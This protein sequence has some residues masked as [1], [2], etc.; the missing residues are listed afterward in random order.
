MNPV[1]RQPLFENDLSIDVPNQ[2]KKVLVFFKPKISGK[3]VFETVWDNMQG[4]FWNPVE[5]NQIGYTQ[6]YEFTPIVLPAGASIIT[7][8]R[9]TQIVIPFGR[10]FSKTMASAAK[11]SYAQSKICFYDECKEQFY[12]DADSVIVISI[13][14]FS[15]K[16]RPM[17]HINFQLRLGI[18]IF[19]KTSGKTK[20]ETIQTELKEFKLGTM[21]STSYG[22]IE[23]MNE[24]I[25]S[26][27]ELS[28]KK[29][30]EKDISDDL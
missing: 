30:I 22:F 20:K 5:S 19:E 18:E 13:N 24:A 3:P 25:N 21:A 2:N 29:V 15:V 14:H 10:V 28:A 23:K 4:P 16:E 26:F 11:K 12:N 8:V 27:S 17:N 1:K 7:T 6:D 9:G